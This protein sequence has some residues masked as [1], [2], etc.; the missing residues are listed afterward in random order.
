MTATLQ[1]ETATVGKGKAV[2]AYYPGR[3]LCGAGGMGDVE[4]KLV[5]GPVTCKTCL[6]GI[7]REVE[8]AHGLAL[9]IEADRVHAEAIEL[10]EQRLVVRASLSIPAGDTVSW[11]G[12]A[13]AYDAYMT[14]RQ[15][16]DQEAVEQDARRYGAHLASWVN[17]KG[18]RRYC[19]VRVP[20]EGVPWRDQTHEGPC[21]DAVAGEWQEEAK[22]TARQRKAARRELRAKVRKAAPQGRAAAK[23]RR[24]RRGTGRASAKTLLVASGLPQDVADRYASAFSRGVP[25]PTTLQAVRMGKRNVRRVEVKGY[26]WE[27]FV[28]RL[29]TY[30]PQGPYARRYFEAAYARATGAPV[31]LLLS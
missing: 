8:Y 12:I 1:Y 11:Q 22:L 5:D 7:A 16:D 15:E 17:I 13:Q 23:A 3:T 19:D 24:V 28:E 29:G 18:A 14:G 30:R 26:T 21:F 2:H 10:D 31:D 25:A 20:V 9:Q 27:Q 6:K 4:G